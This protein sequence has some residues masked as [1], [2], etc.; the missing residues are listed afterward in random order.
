MTDKV[1]GIYR[2]MN[3]KLSENYLV[4]KKYKE[5]LKMKEEGDRTI[6]LL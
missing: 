2:K 4:S 1:K 6:D 3:K 5:F